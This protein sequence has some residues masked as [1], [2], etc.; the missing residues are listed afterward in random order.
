MVICN[1]CGTTLNARYEVCPICNSNI[2]K[3]GAT[4]EECTFDNPYGSRY[5]LKCGKPLK[6]EIENICTKCGTVNFKDAVFC[7]QC[8]NSMIVEEE[9]F[10]KEYV[11][12]LK[13]IVPQLKNIK[14]KLSNQFLGASAEQIKQMTYICPICGKINLNED[15][16]CIRCGRNRRRTAN[17]IA[18]DLVTSFDKA[19]AIEPE[20]VVIIESLPKVQ[21]KEEIAVKATDVANT[22]LINNGVP[23][24]MEMYQQMMAQNAL[25]G[26]QG[27]SGNP[28]QQMMPIIQPIAFVPYV[29]QDQP[30]LQYEILDNE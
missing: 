27:M 1:H 28:N 9:N 26:M 21:P 19:V 2:R 12:K 14:S 23:N 3:Q 11:G 29:S 17:L 13:M 6:M 7:K 5:C 25:Q 8:G 18:K 22:E 15:K 20:I 30:L 16:N 4:C 24:Y 10:D